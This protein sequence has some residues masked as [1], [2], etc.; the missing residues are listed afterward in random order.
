MHCNI[1]L[2][3]HAAAHG[4]GTIQLKRLTDSAKAPHPQPTTQPAAF[5]GTSFKRKM[6]FDFNYETLLHRNQ[7]FQYPRDCKKC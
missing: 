6:L 4:L 1:S 3:Y 5:A 2:G 7:Q